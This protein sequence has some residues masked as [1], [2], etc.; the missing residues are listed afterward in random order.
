[1]RRLLYDEA[2]HALRFEFPDNW[3]TASACT[4]TLTDKGGTELLA[5]D[6]TTVYTA[7][8]TDG[9]VAAGDSAFSVDGSDAMEAGDRFRISK[10]RD[11]SEIV[12]V[13]SQAA[14][15][16]TIRHTFD[17]AHSD[18]SAVSAMYCTYDLDTE[19][20]DVFPVGKECT[21]TW[22]PNTDDIPYTE[23]ATVYQLSGADVSNWREHFRSRYP[24]MYTEALGRLDA[25]YDDAIDELAW[26][27]AAEG[28]DLNDLR[29]PSF[30]R[31]PVAAIM[32]GY[33]ARNEGDAGEFELKT[34]EADLMK[35]MAI[36]SQPHVWFDRDQDLVEDEG[37]KVQLKWTA[38]GPNRFGTW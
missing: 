37:E 5:A 23:Q 3:L 35:Y 36:L 17:Y 9:A 4:I 31:M 24:N 14:K 34:A 7:T 11:T 10:S 27:V 18:E 8:T 20:T 6:A 12:T 28:H 2:D 16:S 22:T 32:A 29:E 1:M 33:V 15:V 26:I 30:I 21:I 13:L 19:D 25:L 38:M